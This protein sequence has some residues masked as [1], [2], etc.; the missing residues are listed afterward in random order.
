MVR[1]PEDA[2][3]PMLKGS[4]RSVVEALRASSVPLTN[5][6]LAQ[7]AGAAGATE[8]MVMYSISQSPFVQTIRR[9]IVAL[10]G[11]V[12]PS[13]L[14][15]AAGKRRSSEPKAS[16]TGQIR[17]IGPGEYLVLFVI[18]GERIPQSFYIPAGQLPAGRWRWSDDGSTLKVR[19]TYIAGLRSKYRFAK[20]IGLL[21]LV[22]RFSRLERE[23]SE[24]RDASEVAKWFGTLGESIA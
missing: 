23:V 5:L 20:G 18:E 24:V 21:S 11:S 2:V 7:L 8:A 1:L 9:G 3:V 10:R 17:R 14:V 12:A 6:E 16:V 22:L 19:R 13:Q 4:E 15:R